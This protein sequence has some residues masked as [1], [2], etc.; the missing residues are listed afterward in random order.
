MR[1]YETFEL[2]FTKNENRDM[3]ELPLS[4]EFIGGGER[5]V[6]RGFFDGDG[7]KIRFLPGKPGGYT[8]KVS[9]AVNAEGHE[10]CEPADEAHHG[11]VK[12]VDTHFE[13]EDG[14]RFIPFGTTVYALA[15][16]DDLLVEE[17]LASLETAPFNKI[18]MC[19]FPKH[20][21]Y[22]HNEPPCYPFEKKADGS[23]DVKRPCIA[24]WHRFEN[25]LDRI[26]KMG[27][28][29]D[30]IL[31][32]PYDRWGFDAMSQA[33]N[34]AYLD[35]LIR[36][37]AAKPGIWWSLANEYDLSKSK[38]LEDWEE[39]EAY[40]AENDP[41]GH[42]LSCHNCFCHWDPRRR[43]ITHASLQTKSLTEIPRW[44]EKYKKP[45]MIDECC[46]EGNLPHFWG[47]ISGKEMVYR[48]WRCYASGAFCT[49]GETFLAE[50]EVLWWAKGG[51]LKGES[52]RRIA[53]LREI[54]ESLPGP[55]E[56][57]ESGLIKIAMMKPEER[58]TIMDMIP[59][60]M[61]S[62][63]RLISESI[64]RM[65][66][67]DRTAHLGGEHEWAAHASE[68]AW[69][70]FNDLQCFGEQTL[71]LPEDKRYRVELIDVWNMT[72]SVI[73]ENVSGESIIR[74]P[75]KEG[76]AVLAVKM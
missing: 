19:V 63:V 59:T 16:Q 54:I 21:D 41:Y 43:N 62:F 1:Q 70:W 48:F 44:I 76:M 40:V 31:F 71:R 12:A 64:H 5:K 15:H 47:S 17:T 36:R 24:F 28:Q 27:I 68:D 72:R 38:S 8:W 26:G 3:T 10:Y 29:T 37:L 50:D 23:W 57:A 14:T 75:G 74:L 22:N 6:V 35:Y 13:F 49:H 55:L 33:D 18:R 9:G 52:P 30:L 32:H 66:V 53:F 20:Y 42:L 45:V 34:L 58:E 56:P 7:Y 11:M 61:Q 46:Y 67:D 51:T 25:I 39:L 69:I 65:A 73:A 60:E 2:Q 4:A